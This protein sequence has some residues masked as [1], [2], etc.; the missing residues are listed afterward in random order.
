[1]PELIIRPTVKFI[2]VGTILA[3]LVVAGL[4]ILYWNY[5]GGAHLWLLA[6][7]VLLLLWPAA[8]RLRRQ[9]T[10]TTITGDRLRY[11][12]GIA[13]RS[14]RNIQLSKIQDVRVDQGI[15]QRLFN[16]GNL[17]IETAGESSR[18][19]LFNVDKPQALADEIMSRAQKGTGI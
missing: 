12:V 16:V 10:K 15:A 2:R 5:G 11:E 18:L 13:A 1:V 3:A 19:T 17:A 14:T 4:D 9:Y 7:P 8:R 6:L